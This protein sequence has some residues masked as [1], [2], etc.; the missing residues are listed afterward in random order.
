MTIQQLK[1]YIFQNSLQPQILQ[2]LE[3]PNIRE[4]DEKI[5]CSNVDGDNLTAICI[6]KNNEY[7]FVDNFT[8]NIEDKDGYRDIFALVEFV[9]ECNR[10]EAIEW[11]KSTLQLDESSTEKKEVTEQ[12]RID[13][14]LSHSEDVEDEQENKLLDEIPESILNGYLNWNN[15]EFLKD[16]ISCETQEEFELGID[17]YSHRATIPIRDELGRL[18][19]VKGRRVWDV[20]DE[21]NPKYLYLKQC[22][23][24]QILYGLYKTLPYIQE[25][26]EVIVC[27]A[28]K[29]VMQLW[30]MGVKNSVAVSG[31]SISEW[32]LIRLEEL[33]VDI[34]IA[35]DK[36]VGIDI[37]QNEV[38][39]F[40]TDHNLYYIYDDNNVL[41]EKQS[42]MDNQDKWNILY[43]NKILYQKEETN[44]WE[45]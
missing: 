20:V 12:D 25:K 31:H 36:D 7:L 2:S 41:D 43:R 45:V 1:Q 40:E 38:D 22:E 42:P 5:Q 27:E 15:T 28:E 32:Q 37:I 34:T 30:D 21:Y 44:E 35:F 33:D 39:K 3:L 8:R 13:Y 14:I 4:D 18:V 11:I 29:G 10:S 17:I 9:R 16:N 24:S 19:G 26:G 23:K 6:Y